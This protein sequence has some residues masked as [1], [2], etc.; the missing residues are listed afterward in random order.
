MPLSN[1]LSMDM[2]PEPAHLAIDQ[3]D[4]NGEGQSVWRHE[5][6]VLLPAPLTAPD[7]LECLEGDVGGPSW[8]EL[9]GSLQELCL[10][11]V[12]YGPSRNLEPMLAEALTVT[13]SDAWAKETKGVLA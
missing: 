2:R 13:L 1:P 4:L 10:T 9:S 5:L 11:V 6:S 12:A 3:R 8:L 7:A